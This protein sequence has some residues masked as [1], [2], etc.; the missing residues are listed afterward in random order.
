MSKC[1]G[2]TG[3][4]TIGHVPVVPGTMDERIVGTAIKKDQSIYQALDAPLT[5]VW[6]TTLEDER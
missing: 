2:Q 6:E 1:M 3:S 5:S 4:Y